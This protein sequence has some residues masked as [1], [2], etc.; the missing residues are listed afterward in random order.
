M[1]QTWILKKYYADQMNFRIRFLLSEDCFL[2]TSLAWMERMLELNL[3]IYSLSHLNPNL[4]T[5]V[6][7]KL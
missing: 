5:K 4:R 3:K 6:Q 7:A 1:L 2:S